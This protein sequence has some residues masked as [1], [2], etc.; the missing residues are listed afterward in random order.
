MIAVLASVTLLV[1]VSYT[2]LDVYKRQMYSYLILVV[3]TVVSLTLG[4]DR[5][6]WTQAAAIA[7]AGRFSLTKMMRNGGNVDL[8]L[9]RNTKSIPVL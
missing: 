3:T 9:T 7:M 5:F 6:S 4:Q 8:Y 1:P 2:H